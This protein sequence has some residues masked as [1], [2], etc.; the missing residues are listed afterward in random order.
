MCYFGGRKFHYAEGAP[1]PPKFTAW[2]KYSAA[3][4]TVKLSSVAV[5]RDHI[6]LRHNNNQIMTHQKLCQVVFLVMP[7]NCYDIYSGL[8]KI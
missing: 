2:C 7:I 6:T 5:I 3:C 4:I 8:P 1:P